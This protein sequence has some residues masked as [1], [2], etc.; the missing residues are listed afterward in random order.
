MKKNQSN[1]KKFSITSNDLKNLNSLLQALKSSLNFQKEFINDIDNKLCNIC[2]YLKIKNNNPNLVINSNEYEL[3]DEIINLLPEFMSQ[4]GIPFSYLLFKQGQIFQNLLSLCVFNEAADDKIAEIFEI[5]L[6]TFDF[7]LYNDDIIRIR[8]TLIEYGLVQNLSETRGNLNSEKFIFEQIFSILNQWNELKNIGKDI[9]NIYKLEESYNEVMKE[10]KNLP[11]KMKVT[12]PHIEFYKELIKP[13]GDYLNS[14]NININLNNKKQNDKYNE[15]DNY[16]IDEK[17]NFNNEIKNI[18]NKPLSERTFFYQN[19]KLQEKVNQVIEFR[20][21]TFPLKEE[22]G[23]D[24]KRQICGFLNSQGGRLYIGINEKNVV[25][26]IFLNYKKRD[27]LGNQL[28]NLTYDFFPKCRL[29]KVLVYFIPIKD[30]NTQA[31]I[32]NLFVIKIR[33]YP[34]DPEILYSMS[35]IGYQ[36]TI[37]TDGI[38]KELNTSEIYNE[39]IKRDELKH[40]NKNNYALRDEK[41]DPDPEVNPKDLEVN[42]ANDNMPMP[43]FEDNNLNNDLKKIKE[44]NPRP[45][46]KLIKNM[47]REGT[48]KVKVTNIDEMIPVNDVNRFFNGCRCASQR[49]FKE[50]YGYLNFSNLVDANNCVINYNGKKIGKKKIRLKII[51]DK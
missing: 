13:L 16:I 39:M 49:F 20:N 35:S 28:V 34:G 50:G 19:E 44:R 42:D 45:K 3:V 8:C 37:R 18:M 6:D 15:Y 1:Y 25:Q 11:S 31:F 41:K 21:Y 24:I 22:N 38:C 10:I 30:F 23:E 4:L 40:N 33:V 29:D 43:M 47:V 14:I 26:G 9:D 32:Q 51:N 7:S 27:N 2:N 46:K 5:F 17:K 48:I 36:S 12:Q